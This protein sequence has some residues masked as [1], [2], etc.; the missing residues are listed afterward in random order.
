MAFQTPAAK[1]P[2][3]GNTHTNEPPAK[4]LS[5]K[6]KGGSSVNQLLESHFECKVRES[7]IRSKAVNKELKLKEREM[8]LK[9]R[10]RADNKEIR[11]A[12]MKLDADLRME[13]LRLKFKLEERR[14][15][16]E[17]RHAK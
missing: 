5:T 11:L 1:P 7:R 9:E 15:E 14:M 12:Q 6:K 13:E 16:L 3:L 8:A 17:G 4:Q 2:P 10:G